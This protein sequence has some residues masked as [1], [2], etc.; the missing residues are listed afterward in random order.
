MKRQ[1]KTKSTAVAIGLR[2][3]SWLYTRGTILAFK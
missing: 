2:L 3:F 1:K